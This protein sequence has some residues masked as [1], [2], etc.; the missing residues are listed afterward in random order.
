MKKV[1]FSFVVFLSINA[2]AISVDEIVT[3]A[4]HMSYYQGV[5][6]KAK[7]EMVI[8][9]AKGRERSRNITILRKDIDD[10][11]D[12]S[13]KFYVYFT[14]PA[15]VNKTAFL[16]WKNINSDDDR[17][18]YLPALDL[19]KRIAA[20]DKRTSFVGSHFFYEDVSGRNPAEDNHELIE[21][22]ND[23]YVINSVPLDPESVEFS[24]YKS[25]IYKASFLPVKAEFFDK[26]GKPYRVFEVLKIE[27]VEGYQTVTAA[28]VLDS[29]IGGYTI[30]S[31]S[32]VDYDIG[33]AEDL[34]TER[35]LRNPPRKELR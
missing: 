18:L 5:D 26:S 15:D 27:D 1:F 13:Q 3:K 32:N 7:V 29:N 2:N 6:G 35:Y 8:T 14:R 10:A 4:N 22:T 31:Y 11:N 12:G 24:K 16:V 19:V 33:F 9:D 20:S 30:M 25:W 23:Y 34:F 28:K 21:E 17:W